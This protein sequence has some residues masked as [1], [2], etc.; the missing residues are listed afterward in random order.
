MNYQIIYLNNPDAEAVTM[1]T[2]TATNIGEAINTF[3]KNYGIAEAQIL[4]I[5]QV[6]EE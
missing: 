2:V 3:T 6:N 1:L 5:I 4:A